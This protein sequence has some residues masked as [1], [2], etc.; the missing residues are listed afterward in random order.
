MRLPT[1]VVFALSSGTATILA[2]DQM[3]S[4]TLA[5]DHVLDGAPSEDGN[6]LPP[7]T[8]IG[9]TDNCVLVCETTRV[10]VTTTYTHFKTITQSSPHA[11]QIVNC[12]EECEKARLALP[13][14]SLAFM[15]GD[16][17]S[18]S[19]SSTSRDS[20]WLK[21]RGIDLLRQDVMNYAGNVEDCEAGC[22]TIPECE[23]FSVSG[24]FP[25]QTC[26]LKKSAMNYALNASVDSYVRMP[27]TYECFANSDFYGYDF[28]S[29]ATSF[30][31][32]TALCNNERKQCKGF[33]WVLNENVNLGQC[34]LKT[35][36]DDASTI[37]STR[38]AISCQQRT[39]TKTT[40]ATTTVSVNDLKESASDD[41][42]IGSLSVGESS[43]SYN[44]VNRSSHSD[45]RSETHFNH[46][47]ISSTQESKFP[48]AVGGLENCKVVCKKTLTKHVTY[49]N[50]RAN[51]IQNKTIDVIDRWLK[52]QGIDVLEQDILS[53]LGLVENCREACDTIP[54]CESF[55]YSGAFPDGMCALKKSA[56]NYVLNA[57]VD[58]YMKM[59][60]TYEC[61]ANSDFYGHDFFSTAS[62]YNDCAGICNNQRNQCNGFTWILNE[63][64]SLGQCYLKALPDSAKTVANARGS[65]SCK[66]SG[67]TEFVAQAVGGRNLLCGCIIL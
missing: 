56:Q 65:I 57:S 55:S 3:A 28:F 7:K 29:T 18:L 54:E 27:A 67:A 40:S 8:I 34:Y 32:C 30:D 25:H 9:P 60:P 12:N 59:P 51:D 36:P 5:E 2:T 63:N 26:W 44:L 31:D 49:Y 61:F 47:S 43:I 58:S 52:V 23:S 4:G 13:I 46:E 50:K 1:L 66:R 53:F 20:Q 19:S 42:S 16:V 10:T 22:E 35:L 24:V 38:G 45:D 14:D 39:T 48:Y 21:V 64:E 41:D 62:S 11:G 17:E 15:R 6:E 37:S 33:T